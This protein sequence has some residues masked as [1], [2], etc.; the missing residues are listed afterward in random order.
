M[1]VHSAGVDAQVTAE[2]PSDGPDSRGLLRFGIQLL[3]QLCS[4]N[5]L[6]Q[7]LGLVMTIKWS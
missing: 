2:A 7:D 4:G 3:F 5:Y 1:L 6:F